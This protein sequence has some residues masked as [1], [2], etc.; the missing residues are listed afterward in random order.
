LILHLLNQ[1]SL[2]IKRENV[3]TEILNT[4]NKGAEL[5]YAA[6]YAFSS[7]DPESW[8]R[9]L[10]DQ[11]QVFGVLDKVESL[12]SGDRQEL[13]ESEESRRYLRVF[14]DSLQKLAFRSAKASGPAKQVLSG[15]EQNFTTDPET[16]NGIYPLF[17]AQ[18]AEEKLMLRER[19]IGEIL[20]SQRLQMIKDLEFT[21]KCG[22]LANFILSVCLAV[23]MMRNLRTRLKHVMENTAR[24]VKREALD[25]PIRGGDE[26]AYL[27]KVFYDAGM[28]L[29][30]LEKFKQELI[31]IVSHELRTPLMSISS[32]LQLFES[33]IF[34]SLTDKG[35]NRLKI[36]SEEANRLIRLINNL[37]DIEKMDAG[38]FV[39]DCSEFD[40]AELVKS[41][42]A[43][44]AQAA[45]AKEIALQQDI[46]DPAMRVHGDRDRL[47]QVLIN[48]LSN[49]IKFSPEKEAITVKVERIEGNEFRFSV[50]D[51]GRGIP[52]EKR[53]KIFDRFV[54]VEKADETVKGGSGLGL[55]ISKAIV[56]QHGGSI[57]VDSE[58]GMGSTFWFKLPVDQH[59]IEL[60][61]ASSVSTK[62]GI[63]TAK[64]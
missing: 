30:E 39:F 59:S 8:K 40:A 25:P 45:E 19:E 34:G 35:V 26:I 43:S 49:A 46:G 20:G 33:D 47:C 18:K 61:A 38:K 44:V 23:F 4:L 3:S 37:L 62:S 1:I 11:K 60:S 42:I 2:Q 58:P 15:Q 55:A 7:K 41:S 56:E 22:V 17:E 32:S 10:D 29:L 24:L 9:C 54:Q 52:E 48:L 36:A 31:S 6:M 63:E 50:I 14:Y 28:H 51:R 12:C 64:S 57:G 21:L 27:D 53:L 13:G 5:Y 16:V